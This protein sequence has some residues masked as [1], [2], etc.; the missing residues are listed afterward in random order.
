MHFEVTG[1]PGAPALVLSNSLGTSIAMW[2]P[3]VA[4]LSEHFR[5]VRYDHRGHGR[6]P[7]LPGPYELADLGRDVLELLAHLEIEQASVCGVSLGGM[8]GM[9]LGANAPHRINRLVLCCTSAYLPPAKSW[10]SRAAIVRKAGTT[11]VIADTVCARWLTPRRH[12]RDRRL[13]DCL[14]AM[15]VATPAE[16]YAA[17]CRSSAAGR[18]AKSRNRP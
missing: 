16:G 6:S 3:Q 1:P 8:V 10:T 18:H 4:E 7:V 12:E 14:R 15:L 2:D 17:C 11:G 9:W 13:A 5:L